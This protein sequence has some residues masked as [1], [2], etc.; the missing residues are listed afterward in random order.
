MIYAC[1]CQCGSTESLIREFLKK[2]GYEGWLDIPIEMGKDRSIKLVERFPQNDK[3]SALYSYLQDKGK[4][5]VLIGWD[6]EGCHWADL[7]AG[8]KSRIDAEFLVKRF[9]E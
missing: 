1:G 7:D 9:A 8:L 5:A 3:M 4:W 6:D 2:Q